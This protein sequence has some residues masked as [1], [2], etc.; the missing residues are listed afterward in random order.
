MVRVASLALSVFAIFGMS[1]KLLMGFLAD[2]IPSRYTLMINLSGQAISLAL[3]I[4]A[5][6]PVVMWIAVP[7]LGYFH[8]AFGALFQLVVQDA[9]SIRHYGSIMGS[10]NLSTSVS[11]GIGTIL[12][13]A[14]FGLTGVTPRC[15]SPW[16]SYSSSARCR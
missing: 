16:L 1:G 8:G 4:W 3:T 12:A 11:F 9:F 14:S 6:S 10:I 5:G 7:L 2:W 15:S 13:G